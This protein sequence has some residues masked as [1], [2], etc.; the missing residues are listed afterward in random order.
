VYF[1]LYY[2]DDLVT[3][4][5]LIPMDR[6]DDSLG[7][8]KDYAAPIS[9]S[10]FTCKIEKS[11]LAEYPILDIRLSEDGVNWKGNMA[12]PQITTGF[13]LLTEDDS[14]AVFQPVEDFED[15]S[16]GVADF[17]FQALEY[18]DVLGGRVYRLRFTND[19]DRHMM[20]HTLEKDHTKKWSY[21]ISKFTMIYAGDTEQLYF[22]S[23]SALEEYHHIYIRIRD[24]FKVDPSGASEQEFNTII[25]NFGKKF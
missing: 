4:I 13:L 22:V 15:K 14:P 21:N 3:A 24:S 6:T 20:F 23:N 5:T 10:V 12:G 18:A 8:M 11:V 25:G 9:G 19:A 17:Q 7:T 16:Y 2:S 1:R